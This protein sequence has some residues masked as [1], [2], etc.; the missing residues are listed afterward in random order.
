M[1]TF[2]ALRARSSLRNFHGNKKIEYDLAA[3]VQ[4]VTPRVVIQTGGVRLGLTIAK[5]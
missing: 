4:S 1:T 3:E 5:Q 2:K